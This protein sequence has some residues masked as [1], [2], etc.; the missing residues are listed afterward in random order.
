MIYCSR[1]IRKS[2]FLSLSLACIGMTSYS[3]FAGGGPEN[4]FLLV[5]SES[6]DSMTVANHYIDIRQLPPQNV[7]Y[8]AWKWK[9]ARV[10]SELIREKL[11]RPALEEINR[12]GLGGQIDYLVYSCD[13][14]WR[15]SF[16]GD[17]PEEKFPPQVSP[18]ASL[19]GATYLSSLVMGKRKE[20]M[21]LTNN[22]YFSPRKNNVT[23]TRGFKSS[24]YWSPQGLRATRE[25]GIPYLLSTMLGVTYGRGNSVDEIV[26]YLKLAAKADGTRPKGTVYYVKN[27]SAR[28]KPRHND[29]PAAVAELKLSGVHAAIEEGTFIRNK[30]QV[31]GVTC[32]APRFKIAGSGCS[33]LPGAIGDNFTSAGGN[34]TVPKNKVGQTPL[35]D[36]LRFGCAGACGTVIEPFAIAQKFPSAFLHV[37]YAHGASLAEAFYQSIQGP[38]Q[39]LVV[40]DPLCQPWAVIPEVSVEGLETGQQYSGTVKVTPSIKAGSGT[41]AKDYQLYIDGKRVQQIPPNG[42]YELDTLTLADGYHEVRVVATGSTPVETQGRWVGEVLVKNGMD[43]VQLS[44]DAGRLVS[45]MKSLNLEVASSKQAKVTIHHNGRVLAEAS[46]GNG[47]VLIPIEKLGTGPVNLTAVSEGEPGL[48]SRSLRLVLPN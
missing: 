5:N 4:V 22:F 36:F 26:R 44:T 15:I 17:F 20:V 38:Y 3:S 33:F 25:S 13:F 6:M 34:L 40:G 12:R 19:T 7:F 45:G 46:R 16:V 10:S 18:H 21:S 14:P 42:T 24:Y 27:D 9:Q 32:G 31:I 23:I 1:R 30:T 39:M 8:V 48:Q 43:A 41:A 47:T 35:S 11:L 28:S 2:I 37:H 29:Y